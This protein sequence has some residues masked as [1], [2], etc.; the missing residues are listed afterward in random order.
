L[1]LVDDDSETSLKDC[2]DR[3]KSANTLFLSKCVES[4]DT[5]ID[6]S[7]PMKDLQR[8]EIYERSGENFILS[9]LPTFASDATLQPNVACD[10]LCKNSICFD[11]QVENHAH[12]EQSAE[13][14]EGSVYTDDEDIDLP[15]C[16]CS[17]KH[18]SR[19]YLNKTTNLPVWEFTVF[20]GDDCEYHTARCT[21]CSRHFCDSNIF[22][23]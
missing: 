17:V 9:P 19:K 4:G 8:Q 12:V 5:N 3:A 14:D 18:W 10:S 23:Y 13:F 22:P 7:L 16:M 20:G 21:P 15:A 11:E 2:V 6:I 1:R